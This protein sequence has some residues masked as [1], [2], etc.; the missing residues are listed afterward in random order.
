MRLHDMVEFHGRIRPD[1][2][3]LRDGERSWTHGELNEISDRVAGVLGA[4]GLGRGDRVSMLS[5]NCFEYY[6][7]YF[8]AAKAGCVMVPLNERLAPP[9]W[10][11]IL[12]DS[13]SRLVVGRGELA[14]GLDSV[15]S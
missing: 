4:A 7:M 5:T 1:S 14:K 15:K 12:N 2:H 6:A 10:V 13:G 3:A 9:E 11:Y 8:G